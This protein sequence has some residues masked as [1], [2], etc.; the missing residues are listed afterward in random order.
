MKFGY[1]FWGHDYDSVGGV[2]W[3]LIFFTASISLT[4]WQSALQTNLLLT[5]PA[6]YWA[7]PA[8]TPELRNLWAKK[9]HCP[10]CSLPILL[11]VSILEE[12]AWNMLLSL[13]L[14]FRNCSVCPKYMKINNSFLCLTIF[15]FCFLFPS[16]FMPLR[17]KFFIWNSLTQQIFIIF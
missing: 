14:A 12:R 17:E 7:Q 15:C 16:I 13:L 4:W 9:Q 10:G 8:Q 1:I 2:H 3:A 5:N 6:D 11:L